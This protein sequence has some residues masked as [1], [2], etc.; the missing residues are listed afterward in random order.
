MF[1]V[2]EHAEGILRDAYGDSWMYVPEVE[3][4]VVHNALQDI[5]IPYE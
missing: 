3:D 5:E 4:Q 2:G 1:P